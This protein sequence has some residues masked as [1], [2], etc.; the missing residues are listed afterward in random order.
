MVSKE[1]PGAALN[2][3]SPFNI[4]RLELNSYQ[5]PPFVYGEPQYAPTLRTP[6]E[7]FSYRYPEET[8]IYSCPFIEHR[9]PLVNGFEAV[10]PL[11]INY[12]FFAGILKGDS[13]LGHSVVYYEPELQF[14]FKDSDSIYK[15]TS[16]EKLQNHLRALLLKCAQEMPQ[17]VTLLNLFSKFRSDPCTKLI[18]QRAKSILAADESFFSPTSPNQRKVGPELPERLARVFTEQMLEKRPG[19]ILTVTQAYTIFSHLSLQKN[20]KPIKRAPFRQM[21][22]DLMKNTFDLSIRR[23]VKDENGLQQE[24]WQGIATLASDQATLLGLT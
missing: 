10:T 19:S 7:W 5:A 16:P 8:R 18:I 12:D 17:N 1:Q 9:Q 13:K 4:P 11:D 2:E 14:Y 22:V 24:G 23:D 3:I 21:M 20:L 6:A 15:T